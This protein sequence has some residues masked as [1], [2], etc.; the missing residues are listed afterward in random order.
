MAMAASPE[1]RR[2]SIVTSIVFI[3]YLIKVVRLKA[4]VRRE[5]LS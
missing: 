5:N 4:E 3:F 1:I 2:K